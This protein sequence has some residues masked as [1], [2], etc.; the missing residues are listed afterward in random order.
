MMLSC[1]NRLPHR[2]NRYV[3]F[4]YQP[5]FQWSDFEVSS[6]V[7]VVFIYKLSPRTIKPMVFYFSHNLS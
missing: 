1:N 4:N 7:D 2:V 6:E 5:Y 3:S